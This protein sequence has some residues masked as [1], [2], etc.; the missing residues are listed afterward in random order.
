MKTSIHLLRYLAELFLAWERFQTEICR[1]KTRVQQS[2]PWKWKCCTTWHSQTGT[3]DNIIRLMRI[4]CWITEATDTHP[5]YVIRAYCVS[6]ATL[7]GYV[8]ARHRYVMHTFL[9]LLLLKWSL[10]RSGNCGGRFGDVEEGRGRIWKP[11]GLDCCRIS[12]RN[13]KTFV[14]NV[15][16]LSCPPYLWVGCFI[17]WREIMSFS[18]V[19]CGEI[20]PWASDTL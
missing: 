17:I 14:P 1:E 9:G 20:Q 6:T 7:V 13:F 2:P 18:N 3:D 16:D 5:E 10:L 11:V 15:G 4:A 8:N 12:A 19:L